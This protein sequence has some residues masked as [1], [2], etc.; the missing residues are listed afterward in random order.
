MECGNNTKNLYSLVNNIKG[1]KKQ[2]PMPENIT[3]ENLAENFADFFL[4]KVLKIRDGDLLTKR[5]SSQLDA[6]TICSWTAFIR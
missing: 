2:N 1:V 3:D 6:R 5:N 4:N